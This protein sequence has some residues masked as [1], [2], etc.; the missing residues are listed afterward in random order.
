MDK[1][2]AEYVDLRGDMVELYKRINDE[3]EEIYA[4]INIRNKLMRIPS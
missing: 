1:K 2:L 4:K 3:N